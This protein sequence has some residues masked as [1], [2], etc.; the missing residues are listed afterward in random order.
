MSVRGVDLTWIVV[1]HESARDIPVLLRSLSPLF[2]DERLVVE[3]IVIDNASSDGSADLAQR[4]APSATV[5]RNTCNSGYGSAINQA[6]ELAAGRWVAFGN[7]DLFVPDGGLDELPDVLSEQ[8]PDV[9]VIGPAIHASD[10]R[11]DLSAGRFPTLITLLAGLFRPCH[12]RKYLHERDHVAGPVNWVT[13]ACLFARRDAL[14]EVKGFDESFFLYYEDVDLAR[15]LTAAGR[16]TVFD[17]RL[18]IVHVR[19][20]HGRPPQ[21]HIEARVRESRSAYFDKHRP[22]WEAAALRMLSRLEIVVRRRSRLAPSFPDLPRPHPGVV[23]VVPS[24]AWREG[25]EAALPASKPAPAPAPSMA[26]S[27]GHAH[28]DPRPDVAPAGVPVNGSARNGVAASATGVNGS[29]VNGAQPN[30]HAAEVQGHGVNGSSTD[31]NSQRA[32]GNGPGT[33]LNGSSSHPSQARSD[34]GAEARR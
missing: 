19:P 20:H 2:A 28:G 17:P 31:L 8:S 12:R 23:R 24:G 32:N 13:G 14:R 15:R 25:V 18:S 29:G 3:L 6:L 26:A 34:R 5:I 1:T 11:Y 7:A 27:H 33:G 4:L 9:A 10:G 22:A 21:P 16:S 30:G